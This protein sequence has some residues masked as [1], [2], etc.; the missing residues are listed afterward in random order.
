[1]KPVLIVPSENNPIFKIEHKGQFSHFFTSPYSAR[2]RKTTDEIFEHLTN[3]YFLDVYLCGNI[4][5]KS[6][7]GKDSAYPAHR[8]INLIGIGNHK[9]IE[10]I[11]KTLVMCDEGR[12]LRKLTPKE[13]KRFGY[14]TDGLKEKISSQ[15]PFDYGQFK[16]DVENISIEPTGKMLGEHYYARFLFKPNNDKLAQVDLTL[17]RNEQFQAALVASLIGD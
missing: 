16:F 6:L 15:C 7:S 2:D 10:A 17:A 8:Q 9:Q 5:N 14:S 4:V 11:F 12:R 3:R 1:M 13:Q